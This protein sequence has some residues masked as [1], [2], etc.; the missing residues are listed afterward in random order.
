MP[1]SN[2][3]AGACIAILALAPLG[4][5]LSDSSKSISDSV[6]S[7]FTSSSKS[8][9]S[10]SQDYQDDVRD[11]TA[12]YVKGGGGTADGLRAGLTSVAK[13]H[14]ISNWE[15]DDDTYVGV[16]RG[17]AKGGLNQA[18]YQGYRDAISGGDAGKSSLVDKG[19]KSGGGN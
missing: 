18:S 9:K 12:G 14:G 15:A 13:S 4:C 3:L 5:S 7:P 11:Y 16:G 6:S 2:R 10:E 1:I 17:L 19:Y 8:S